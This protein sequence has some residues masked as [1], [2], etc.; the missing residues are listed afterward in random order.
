MSFA[1]FFDGQ[2]HRVCDNFSWQYGRLHVVFS[3]VLLVNNKFS[4][5]SRSRL[6]RPCFIWQAITACQPRAGLVLV[7]AGWLGHNLEG[8][9]TT[10]VHS[11]DM[12]VLVAD[13][14]NRL[15]FRLQPSLFRIRSTLNASDEPYG[16][17][18]P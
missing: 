16:F 12:A 4:R 3:S 2:V 15:G 18:L 14:C 1:L 10:T 9:T 6:T 5:T 7:Q 8:V 11:L 17:D 13:H